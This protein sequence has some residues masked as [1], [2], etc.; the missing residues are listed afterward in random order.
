MACFST[1][2]LLVLALA[3]VSAIGVL[4]HDRPI[5]GIDVDGERLTQYIVVLTANANKVV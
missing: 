4:R 5:T 2:V 1:T 3:S